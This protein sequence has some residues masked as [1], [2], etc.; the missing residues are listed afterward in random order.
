M[1]RMVKMMSATDVKV[2]KVVEKGDAA[3]LTVTGKQ[4]GSVERRR[5]HGPKEGGAWK[6][7][8]EEWEN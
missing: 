6:V 5:P 3:D 2:L 1:V 4:D 7:Q 8:Q